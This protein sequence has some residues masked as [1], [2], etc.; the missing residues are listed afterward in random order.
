M[1]I[2]GIVMDMDGVLW[3]GD[4]PLPGMADFIAFLRQHQVPFALATNN[5]SKTPD[6]YIGKLAR[7]DVYDVNAAQIV[8]SGIA[9]ASYMQAR[10]APGT[11]VYVL[12]MSGLRKVIADAGF[13]IVDEPDTAAGEIGRAHV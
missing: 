11:R 2:T 6:D 9:T 10:Y 13:V 4:T 1:R 7:M 8:N 3:R 5:S 12:G